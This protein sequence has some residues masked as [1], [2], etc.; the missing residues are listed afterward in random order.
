MHN[1]FMCN[2][3][4][5]PFNFLLRFFIKYNIQNWSSSHIVPWNSRTYPV[6]RFAKH[7]DSCNK[8]I[9]QLVTSFQEE[10][11]SFTN[12][13]ASF[14]TT[15]T[16]YLLTY[17]MDTGSFVETVNCTMIHICNVQIQSK[18]SGILQTF[19]YARRWSQKFHF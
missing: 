7:V 9:Q 13:L 4:F 14:K 6:L 17:E 12:S 1:L 11:I 15:I 5:S 10:M 2:Q 3:I 18:F 16:V 8:T 19:I